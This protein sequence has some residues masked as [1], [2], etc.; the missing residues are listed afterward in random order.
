MHAIKTLYLESHLDDVLCEMH[1]REGVIK[2]TNELNLSR[3]SAKS[4][5]SDLV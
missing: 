5:H 3:F 1:Y 2:L 4:L